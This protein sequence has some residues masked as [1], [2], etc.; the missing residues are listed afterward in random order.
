MRVVNRHR[1]PLMLEDGTLLAAAG[2]K[3]AEREVASLGERDRRLVSRGLVVVSEAEQ[4][5]EPRKT[6][7]ADAGARKEKA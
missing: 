2:T 5:I 1:Q 6:T 4:S 3:G 7:P